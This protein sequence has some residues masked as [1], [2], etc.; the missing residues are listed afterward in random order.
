[1]KFMGEK[2]GFM[3]RMQ[4]SM[5][6]LGKAAGPL[7]IVFIGYAIKNAFQQWKAAPETIETGDKWPF[8]DSTEADTR[9]KLDMAALAASFGVGWVAAILGGIDRHD[10]RRS[11]WWFS[12]RP[13]RWFCCRDG[14]RPNNE[15]VTG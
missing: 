5:K 8:N 14:R 12:W 7:A 1:M 9:F 10:N 15:M 6:W 3:N 2:P 11:Y 4:G 13:S